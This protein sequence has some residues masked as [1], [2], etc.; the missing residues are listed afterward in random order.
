MVNTLGKLFVFL[1]FVFSL[2]FL[3]LAIGVYA[4]HLTFKSKD[5]NQPGI[6]D[7]LETRIQNQAFGR[8]RAKARYNAAYKELADVEMIR[9]QRQ[10]FYAAKIEM[11]RSGKD[12]KGQPVNTPVYVM[13]PGPD[14]FIPMKMVGDQN[15]I[16]Q[17]RGQPLQALATYHQKLAGLQMEIVAEQA[18]IDRL[19]NELAAL[20][21]QMQGGQD[22]TMP[23]RIVVGLIEQKAV[24]ADAR[25]RAINSQEFLKPALANRFAEAVILLKREKALRQR[26]EQLDKGR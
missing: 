26:L 20:T 21:L 1:V 12:E 2:G 5:K 17:V 19:Q 3:A 13:Q 24:Q 10:A 7:K 14:G 23:G 9:G 11:L 4:N 16:M 8:D 22:P 6:I 15:E 18:N 25:V